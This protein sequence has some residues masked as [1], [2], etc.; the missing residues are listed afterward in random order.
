MDDYRTGMCPFSDLLTILDRYPLIV[1]GKNTNSNLSALVYVI[2]TP[3][4]PEVTWHSRT[5]ELLN[6]LI[7]RITHIIS[8]DMAWPREEEPGM[9]YLKDPGTPYEMMTPEQVKEQYP[10]LGEASA[11]TFRP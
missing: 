7:R 4:R 1:E 10:H 11:M 9:T 5:P 2:T 3:Y 8:F 6:Q